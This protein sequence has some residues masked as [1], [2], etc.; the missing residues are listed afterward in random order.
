MSQTTTDLRAGDRMS[1]ARLFA[2]LE[3]QDMAEMLGKSRNTV[4][5]W[6]RGLNDPPLSA[7]AT[8][9]MITGRS[10]DWIVWGDEGRPVNEETPATAGVSVGRARRDSNPQPSDPE[11]L[12]DELRFWTIVEHA[13]VAS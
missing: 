12:D 5:A 7:V 6:E 1:R 8:W 11:S 3:Q 4:S 10:I 13:A 9:A 2:G